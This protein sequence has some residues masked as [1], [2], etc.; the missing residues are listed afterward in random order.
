MDTRWT[1]SF[2]RTD[3]STNEPIV[4]GSLVDKPRVDGPKEPRD[5]TNNYVVST[6]S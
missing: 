6:K 2:R 5:T 1:D 3:C 4:D